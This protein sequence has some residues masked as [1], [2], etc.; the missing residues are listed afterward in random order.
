M[1]NLPNGKTPRRTKVDNLP[2]AFVHPPDLGVAEVGWVLSIPHA[3]E[4]QGGAL[5]SMVHLSKKSC[6]LHIS[7]YYKDGS[8]THLKSMQGTPDSIFW[9]AW[10]MFSIW[11]SKKTGS[12]TPFHWSVSILYGT[13]P[14]GQ[15]DFVAFR[16]LFSADP[17][18]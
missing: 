17:D 13:L 11:S 15:R 4:D 3:C 2:V 7:V 8:K 6:L 16:K 12:T 14:K 1:D 9:R 5:V 18:R 10:V